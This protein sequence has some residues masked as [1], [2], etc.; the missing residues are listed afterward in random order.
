VGV[1]F[2]VSGGAAISEDTTA[3]YSVIWDS[4]TVSD[5]AHTITAVARDAAGNTTTSTINVTVNN[6]AV[7][8][9]DV[10]VTDL[11]YN[12]GIFTSVV[13]NQGSKA[14]PAGVTVGVGYL[15]DGKN[16]TWGSIVGPLAAG[17]SVTIA[18]GGS[19]Y[20]IPSGNHSIVAYV[21]DVNR[22]AESNED[23]NKLTQ[24]ITIP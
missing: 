18:M 11:S 12:N 6:T 19:A 15:V 22:F 10:V 2:S 1:Q 9:P 16:R 17:A 5:G 3:P 8:M 24:S 20:M 21:D 23:N 14:T 13:K 4:N 7:P